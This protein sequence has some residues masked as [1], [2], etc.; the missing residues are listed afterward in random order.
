MSLLQNPLRLVLKALAED[1]SPKQLAMGVALGMMLGLLP[2]GNLLAIALMTVFCAARINL[3]VGTLAALVFSGIAVFLDPVTHVIGMNVLTA[4]WLRPAWTMFYNM[5]V[6]PWTRFNNTVV[7]GNLIVGVVLFYPTYR[8]GVVGFTR[9]SPRVAELIGR[10]RLA[11][12]LWKKP[13]SILDHV[14]QP[15]VVASAS[16]PAASEIPL[17]DAIDP[18][19][20][21]DPP[22]A[23]EVAP[24][25]LPQRVAA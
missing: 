18:F 22:A 14:P 19:D 10:S 16:S 25:D 8:I 1:C 24:S 6:A 7:L 20:R 13:G 9:I 17:T 12:W 2:K 21:R 23:P 3:G 5:P 15:V 4:E 11:R